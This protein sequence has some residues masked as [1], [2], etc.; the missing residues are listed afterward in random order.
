MIKSNKGSGFVRNMQF[1]DFISRGTAYGLNVNQFWS[2]QT[3]GQG[4]GVQLQNI[5]FSV[6]LLLGLRI[7]GD[8]S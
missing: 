1:N 7:D 4:A 6:R 3:P 8:P 5:T 2:S